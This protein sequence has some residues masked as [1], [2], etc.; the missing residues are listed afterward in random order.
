MWLKE[1]KELKTA[2]LELGEKPDTSK[3]SNKK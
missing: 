1:L 3:K 2:Y